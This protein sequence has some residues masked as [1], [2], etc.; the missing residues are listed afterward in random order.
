MVLLTAAVLLAFSPQSVP[1]VRKREI[2]EYGIHISYPEIANAG[3]FDVAVHQILDPVIAAFRKGMPRPDTPDYQG[4]LNGSYTA[5]I[6]KTGIVSALLTWDEYV[7]GA[8]HPGGF[9]ASIN[10]DTRTG[11]VLALSDLFRSGVNYVS[12]LSETAIAAL[13]RQEYADPS[14]VRRGAGPVESNF[15]VFTLTDTA[16]VLHFPTYQV[17]AGAAG[18]QTVV[19]P[20]DTVA[21]LLRKR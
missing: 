19:I 7:P 2:R 5:A 20:L 18:P 1:Q 8:A 15:K 16:L 11:R 10:Y 13:E 14:A 4:Y 17:A 9:M 21:P 12:R 3:E 6:L